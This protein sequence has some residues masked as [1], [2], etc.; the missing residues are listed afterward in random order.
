[1][2]IWANLVQD[3]S[4]TWAH[5]ISNTWGYKELA[6]LRGDYV[7]SDLFKNYD[8]KVQDLTLMVGSP[9]SVVSTS[10]ACLVAAGLVA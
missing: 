7:G 9:F 6:S 3:S 1:M 4:D 2:A 10:S 8:C 5:S